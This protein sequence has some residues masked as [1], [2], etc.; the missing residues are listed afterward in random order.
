MEFSDGPSPGR[1]SAARGAPKAER[2]DVRRGSLFDDKAESGSLDWLEMA[3]DTSA[4]KRLPGSG[5]RRMSH[6][7]Q[8]DD[9]LGTRSQQSSTEKADLTSDYLGLGSEIDLGQKPARFDSVVLSLIST[10]LFFDRVCCVCLQWFSFWVSG[11]GRF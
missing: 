5:G 1:A 6:S 7:T 11:Q 10:C 8:Q 9:W 3:A 4:E 2:G